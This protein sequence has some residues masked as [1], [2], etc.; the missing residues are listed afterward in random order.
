MDAVPT[1]GDIIITLIA[2]T[3]GAGLTTLVSWLR[4][5]AAKRRH[6]RP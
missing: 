3:T 4:K 1:T 5:P 6:A 2:M